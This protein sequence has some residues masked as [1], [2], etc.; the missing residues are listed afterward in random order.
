MCKLI[1]FLITSLVSWEINTIANKIVDTYI[2][3]VNDINDH[4]ILYPKVYS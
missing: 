4:T 1:A 2:Q 3:N